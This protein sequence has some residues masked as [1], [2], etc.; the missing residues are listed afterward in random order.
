MSEPEA[1]HDPDAMEVSDD[2]YGQPESTVVSDLDVPEPM[3]NIDEVDRTQVKQ[4]E[5][6][7]SFES[8]FNKIHGH[9][10]FP[11]HAIVEQCDD[12]R[13]FADLRKWESS[14]ELPPCNFKNSVFPFLWNVKEINLAINDEQQIANWNGII[15]M[16]MTLPI[17][18]YT[19]TILAMTM[20]SGTGVPGPSNLLA[21][22]S[23]SSSVLRVYYQILHVAAESR[24]LNRERRKDIMRAAGSDLSARMMSVESVIR[25]HPRLAALAALSNFS[26][27]LQ[28]EHDS[29]YEVLAR[30]FAAH[31]HVYI[32]ILEVA[33]LR[34]QDLDPNSERGLHS[35][36]CES[37]LPDPQAERIQPFS[38]ELRQK[39]CDHNK[40]YTNLLYKIRTNC[41]VITDDNQAQDNVHG[42]NKQAMWYSLREIL[43]T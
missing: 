37:A 27:S 31:T 34:L 22:I 11:W 10:T 2:F 42:I 7:Y 36:L 3:A 32:K 14:E 4:P 1:T 39:W 17:F 5:T 26:A 8:G 6:A 9:P 43:R 41:S 30:I 15:A 18:I 13:I 33:I 24:T 12:G 35:L 21:P 20:A 16:S 28:P 23:L 40:N 25:Q 38:N 29:T 19:P